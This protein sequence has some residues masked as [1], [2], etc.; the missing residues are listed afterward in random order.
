MNDMKEMEVFNI[1]LCNS[2]LN[3]IK[4]AIYIF[5]NNPVYNLNYILIIII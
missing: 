2:I 5:Y 4:H 3:Y 1:V